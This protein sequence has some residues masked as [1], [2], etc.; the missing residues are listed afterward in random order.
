MEIIAGLAEDHVIS[1]R[2]QALTVRCIGSLP[3]DF[4][5]DRGTQLSR[6]SK[7]ATLTSGSTHTHCSA[8]GAPILFQHFVYGSYACE[9]QPRRY[10]SLSKRQAG[11]RVVV[12]TVHPLLKRRSCPMHQAQGVLA[13]DFILPFGIT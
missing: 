8:A 1:C 11:L 5:I 9:P 6:I 10:L 4:H 13:H 2:C 3:S 12:S 7:H